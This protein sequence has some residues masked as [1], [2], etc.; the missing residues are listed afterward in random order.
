MKKLFI[1]V[2]LL[3]FTIC[4]KAQTNTPEAPP[5]LDKITIEEKVDSSK[6]ITAERIPEFPGG[7][8]KFMSYVSKNFRMPQSSHNTGKVIVAFII[9]KDG[10]VTNV[11]VSRGLSS[12]IDNEAIR[13]VSR[14]PK[15]LPGIQNGKTLRVGYSI[16]ITIN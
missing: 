1:A 5:D 13:V 16:P 6:N 4:V 3:I 2:I 12:D 14:S 7:I 9:E 10:S 11:K 8:E 15:W